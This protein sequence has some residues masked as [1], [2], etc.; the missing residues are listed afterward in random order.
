MNRTEFFETLE[1]YLCGHLEE[2]HAGFWCDGFNATTLFSTT[3]ATFAS[4]GVWIMDLPKPRG[5]ELWQFRLRVNERLG[6]EDDWSHLDTAFEIDFQ[7]CF[8]EVRAGRRGTDF[9]YTD[10]ESCQ[11][12]VDYLEANG[13]LAAIEAADTDPVVVTASGEPREIRPS[14]DGSTWS[15]TELSARRGGLVYG[16]WKE[17][18][19][20]LLSSQRGA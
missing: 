19:D 17:A 2:A 9:A 18:C 15:V 16:S 3:R 13:I 5:N 12:V 10:L 14:L 11:D 6:E 20:Y 1:F 4:G 7:S 8:I